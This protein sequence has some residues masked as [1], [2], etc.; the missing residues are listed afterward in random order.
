MATPGLSFPPC[1]LGLLI[2]RPFLRRSQTAGEYENEVDPE[3]RARRVETSGTGGRGRPPR[4]VG[5]RRDG[6]S[7]GTL[8]GTPSRYQ[9]YVI[10][11]CTSFSKFS[12]LGSSARKTRRMHNRRILAFRATCYIASVAFTML[13]PR[14]LKIFLVLL[15]T[16]KRLIDSR[17]L[18]SRCRNICAEK[19]N[20][21]FLWF[22]KHNEFKPQLTTSH[23]HYIFCLFLRHY[24]SQ[25]NMKI[26]THFHRIFILPNKNIYFFHPYKGS[27]KKRT[28]KKEEK[29][30]VFPRT[31]TSGADIGAGDGEAVA[32]VGSELYRSKPILWVFSRGIP[33]SFLRTAPN[34]LLTLTIYYCLHMDLLTCIINAYVHD[35]NCGGYVVSVTKL[36][37]YYD[38]NLFSFNSLQLK[39]SSLAARALLKN[40]KNRV[41]IQCMRR[42]KY[43]GSKLP[44]PEYRQKVS[45]S[46]YS[47]YRNM[48]LAVRFLRCFRDL[49]T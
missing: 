40:S 35:N 21:F 6:E 18:I 37:R 32:E 26:K 7:R 30:N 34:D 10:F 31:K 11:S 8:M 3:G 12:T 45:A 49:K 39:Y 2:F 48:S 33:T 5:I 17:E 14:N 27:T 42:R 23:Y 15:A 1:F 28:K 29:K 41:F 36:L 22:S 13:S 43:D 20:L 24:A 44:S 38:N 9:S 16:Y 46:P 25:M 4:R 19:K 47:Y